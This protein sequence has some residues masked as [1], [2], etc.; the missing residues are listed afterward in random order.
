[1]HIL[2]F[3]FL[4]YVYAKEREVSSSQA[5]EENG[6]RGK[7]CLLV[8]NFFSHLQL[9]VLFYTRLFPLP[10]DASWC[11]RDW[12]LHS[13]TVFTQSRTFL[14]EYAGFFDSPG[15]VFHVPAVPAL[16]QL[17]LK[18]FDISGVFHT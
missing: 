4:I 10:L 1:M 8:S 13:D 11:I 12:V 14:I 18:F 5:N 16:R 15:G 7:G 6:S 9:A 2:F 17:S 3:F